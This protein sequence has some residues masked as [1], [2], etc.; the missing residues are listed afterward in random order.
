MAG[1]GLEVLK[2]LKQGRFWASQ[3]MGYF[4]GFGRIWWLIKVKNGL[5][6]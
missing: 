6:D 4:E 3:K 2:K 5:F 1:M